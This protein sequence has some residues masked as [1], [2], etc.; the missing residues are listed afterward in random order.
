MLD[1]EAWYATRASPDEGASAGDHRPR[2]LH[3]PCD[4]ARGAS[5]ADLTPIEEYSAERKAEFLLSNAVD[6][7]DYAWAV[8][9]VRKLGV[10]PEAVPHDRPRTE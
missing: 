5:A 6:E 4:K 3:H 7:Q 1:R 8:H 9:E 10:A 2:Y